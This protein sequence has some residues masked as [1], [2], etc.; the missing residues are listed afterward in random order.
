M[1]FSRKDAKV[2]QRCK[3]ENAPFTSWRLCI[4]APL[5]EAFFD[6]DGFHAAAASDGYA[7]DV[8]IYCLGSTVRQR[9]MPCLCS[10][11]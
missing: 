10:Q 11:R 5:R 2:T 1:K 8:I 3:G 7:G 4:L 6:C 9:S